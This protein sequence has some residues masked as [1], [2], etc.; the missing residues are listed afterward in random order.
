MPSFLDDLNSSAIDSG[1]QAADDRTLRLASHPL[2]EQELAGLIWYQE[3]YLAV[4]EPNPSAEGLAQAHAEGLKASG[5]EFKHVGLGLALLR[6]YCGQRWAVNKLKDKLKQLESQGAEV[7]EL[8]GRVRGELARLERTDAF[9]RRYGEGPIALLQKHE[10]TLLGLHT[11][12]TRVL[13]RG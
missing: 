2:T 12:M 4:A 13:S 8:R 3:S 1:I 11:R 7:D 10:E 5:L 9:V 6:A